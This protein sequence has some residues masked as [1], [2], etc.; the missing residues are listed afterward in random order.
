MILGRGI[1]QPSQ[2]PQ[3]H[4]GLTAEQGVGAFLGLQAP[5]PL[6]RLDANLKA[7]SV[8]FRAIPTWFSSH[9]WLLS[10]GL[11]VHGDAIRGHFVHSTLL[12]HVTQHRSYSRVQ[13]AR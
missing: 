9:F 12:F 10:R 5:G 1:I 8:T 7:F 13:R 4:R 6:E 2:D 11:A 3:T